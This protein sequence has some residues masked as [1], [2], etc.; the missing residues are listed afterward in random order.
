[1]GF[2]VEHPFIFLHEKLLRGYLVISMRTTTYFLVWLKG[3]L[4]IQRLDHPVFI[5]MTTV[6]FSLRLGSLLVMP[7]VGLLLEDHPI[8]LGRT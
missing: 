2:T 1:M 4:Y 5:E 3:Y 7:S 8:I 6:L